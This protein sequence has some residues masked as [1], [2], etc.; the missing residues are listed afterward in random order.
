MEID[1]ERGEKVNPIEGQHEFK[2]PTAVEGKNDSICLDKSLPV[3]P[4]ALTSDP[5]PEGVFYIEVIKNGSVILR[6][7]IDKPKLIFGRSRDADF[8]MDHSSLSRFHA[9]LLWNPKDRP[10]GSFFLIDL[11]SA[12]GTMVNKAKIPANRPIK[13][14]TGNDIIKFGASSR[15]FVLGTTLTPSEEDERETLEMEEAVHKKEAQEKED[16]GCSWGFQDDED[17]ENDERGEGDQAT[18]LGK[19]L[20][21]LQTGG[22]SATGSTPNEHAY[23][24]NPQK[25]IEQWFDSEGYDF[26]YKVDF[27]NGMFKCTIQLPFDGQDVPID[28]EP[29]PKKKDALINVC[30]RACQVLDRAEL[31]FPWQ[32]QKDL[33]RK[34]KDS[35]DSE[36]EVMDETDQYKNK[37]AKKLAAKSGIQEILNFDKLNER[38]KEISQELQKLKVKAATLTI[39]TK[40]QSIRKSTENEKNEEDKK[41][42]GDEENV[43]A[44][45]A[46]MEDINSSDEKPMKT[47]LNVKIE[48]SKL[49]M[50]IADLEKEQ[51][52]VERLIKIAKPSFT[53]PALESVYSTQSSVQNDSSSSSTI[54]S[55]NS[56]VKQSIVTD[57]PSNTIKINLNVK[58]KQSSISGDNQPIKPEPGK[59]AIS[60]TKKSLI[61]KPASAFTESEETVKAKVLNLPSSSSSSLSPLPKP[62]T[63]QSASSSEGDEKFGLIIKKTDKSKSDKLKAAIK[64]KSNYFD[65]E[66]YVDWLPPK[67]QTGDGRTALNDKYGY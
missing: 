2:A 12:H 56:S 55:S 19:V 31:L 17:D 24:E 63:S 44:L 48:Q 41:P 14:K 9:C 3:I 34:K 54:T 49:R 23:S 10:H 37:K 62:S 36:D 43:D 58:P 11:N 18:P 4:D 45:D 52:K 20:Y 65:Q 27:N 42:E 40:S 32:R 66:A 51:A 61:Q 30:L 7:E 6:K 60:L 35:S 33:K 13:V 29:T 1:D 59:I 5:V 47:S 38:W 15:L 46:F 39:A 28:G 67:G 16:Q 53:L 22:G 64:E 57:K 25:S 21:L 26:E 50:T 8:P